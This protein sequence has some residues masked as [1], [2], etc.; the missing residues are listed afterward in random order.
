MY[1]INK[2]KVLLEQ[3]RT[4]FHTQDLALLWGITNSNTLRTTI[5]RYLKTG[6]LKPIHK[7]LYTTN[8][9]A[10]LDPITLARAVI[11]GYCYLSCES[12]LFHQ[13]VIHQSVPSLTFVASR[14]RNFTLPSGAT[15]RVRQLSPRYLMNTLGVSNGVADLERAAADLLHYAPSYYLDSPQLLDSDKL[16]HYQKL[17]GYQ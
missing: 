15:V 13:G 7:G 3:D 17:L 5:S 8:N 6:L 12:V 11:H 9:P 4:L 10:Q 1:T 14:T 2:Q 16:A